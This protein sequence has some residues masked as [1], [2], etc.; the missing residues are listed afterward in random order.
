MYLGVKAVIV[1]IFARIHRANL[2]NFGILPLTFAREADHAELRQG[3]LLTIPKVASRL[4]AGLPLELQTADKRIAVRHSLTPRQIDIILAG[5]L[6]NSMKNSTVN[7]R[8]KR[9]ITEYRVCRASRPSCASLAHE[10]PCRADASCAAGGSRHFAVVV[11][12]VYLPWPP[13]SRDAMAGK[14]LYSVMTRT[15]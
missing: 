3:D 2:I 12:R 4:R 6:L 14:T 7:G 13:P 8:R 1:K 5:G 11:Q 10:P 15:V 9:G